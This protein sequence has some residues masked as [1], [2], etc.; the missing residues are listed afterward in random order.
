MDSN[1]SMQTPKKKKSKAKIITISIIA[2]IGLVIL[3][4]CFLGTFLTY[5]RQEAPY[6]YELSDD[7]EY[8]ILKLNR[9]K[10]I[11]DKSC[12]ELPAEYKG[13]PIY[14]IKSNH[15]SEASVSELIIPEGVKY[16]SSL[17]GFVNIKS[18]SFPESLERIDYLGNIPKEACVSYEG[19]YYVGSEANPHLILVSVDEFITDFTVHTNTKFI[20]QR[21]FGSHEFIENITLPSGLLQ[22]NDLPSD[23]DNL[24]YNEYND[25]YYLGSSSNP[26][27]VYV[28]AMTSRDAQP[29]ELHPDTKIL[30][31]GVGGT[32]LPNGI[33]DIPN[34]YDFNGKIPNS[35]KYIDKLENCKVII[36]VSVIYISEF[37]FKNDYEGD[38]VVYYEGSE[39]SWKKI[40]KD[41][42][43]FEGIEIVFNYS[44]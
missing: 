6:L 33:I 9:L 43:D 40:Q 42:K 29:G 12:V 25:R 14:I 44:E 2:F 7:G 16:V 21:A 30:Y 38:K 8:Y 28:G 22:I 24:K 37:S 35:V 13:K 23:D 17:G 18:I 10:N 27:M 5:Q 19:G 34:L 41:S 39:E 36:P 11:K 26:Y 4:F 20:D 32:T 31:G 1:N 15:V 3:A